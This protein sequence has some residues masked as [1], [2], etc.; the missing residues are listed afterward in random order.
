MIETTPTAEALEARLA[1]LREEQATASTKLQEA[2]AA[3]PP[4]EARLEQAQRVY[5]TV[6]SA[7]TEA[8]LPADPYGTWTPRTP[9]EEEQ[10]RAAAERA[11]FMREQADNE[12]GAAL[13]ARTRAHQQRG[14][15]LTVLRQ[16]DDAIEQAERDLEEARREPERQRDLLAGIRA[17]ILGQRGG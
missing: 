17:R 4:A 14:L 13:V 16:V 6:M 7:G 8:Q 2:E 5:D 15:W 9:Q 1:A 10:A 12:L 11:G 3:I